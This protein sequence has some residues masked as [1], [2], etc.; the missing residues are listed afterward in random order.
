MRPSYVSS[1]FLTCLQRCQQSP[2]KASPKPRPRSRPTIQRLVSTW[3]RARTFRRASSGWATRRAG[4]RAAPSEFNITQALDWRDDL[5]IRYGGQAAAAGFTV[6]TEKLD[7]LR[8]HLQTPTVEQLVGIELQR[9]LSI[10]AEIPL[11]E[12]DWSAHALLSEI[13]PCGMDNPQ[14][15]LVRRDVNVRDGRGVA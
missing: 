15:V 4:A 12:V 5:L 6:A 14:P 9:T 8:H 2:R 11:E 3:R 10:D 13:E 1:R 7:A